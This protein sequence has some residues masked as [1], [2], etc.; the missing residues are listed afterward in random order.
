[1]VSFITSSAVATVVATFLSSSASF[2]C[3]NAFVA[4]SNLPHNKLASV[5]N[6]ASV[7]GTSLSAINRGGGRTRGAPKP[8]EFVPPMNDEIT[9]KEVRVTVG[10]KEGK[11]EILGVMSKAQALAK[12]QELGGLDL[13]LI[14][15]N[16]DPPVCKIVDY[17]KYRYMQEKKRKEKAKNSKATEIK[18]V[19]MSYKIGEHDY[20]V[21]L[22]AASKFI[23]QGNRVKL[24]V[25]FRGREVQHDRLG[26][27]L[28]ERLAKDLE[29]ICNMEGKPRREGRNL[30]AILTPRSEVVK[31]LNDA[32]RLREKEKKKAKAETLAQ[33]EL[34]KKNGVIIVDGAVDNEDED[35]ED[36][37]DDDIGGVLAGIDL[38]D[39][40]DDEF[41]DDDDDMDASLDELLGTSKMTDDLFS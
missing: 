35:D 26:V 13:I 11:D 28:M 38:D 16:S 34:Q 36:D 18:E 24:T 22:K 5:P 23:K 8:T 37:E 19:K 39:D 1:M 12:A 33:R 9:E 21:R 7:S 40:E 20:D 14:N 27:D 31:A 32:K 6:C 29:D 3:A 41:D 15:P 17:S 25:Q 30:G 4:P 10:T 2:H